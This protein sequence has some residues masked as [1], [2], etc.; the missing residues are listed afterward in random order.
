MRYDSPGTLG[1]QNPPAAVAG[2][3]GPTTSLALAGTSHRCCML[4]F[5]FCSAIAIAK[6]GQCRSNDGAFCFLGMVV[7]G[8]N[9]LLARSG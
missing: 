1:S 9:L 2:S 8:W 3:S 7:F 5:V 4:C 6:L